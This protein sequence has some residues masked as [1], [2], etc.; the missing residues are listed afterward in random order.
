MGE[1]ALRFATIDDCRL[2]LAFIRELA[3]YE[4]APD[5]VLASEEDLRTHGFGPQ[6]HF[7][8]LI[9]TLDGEPAGFALFYPDFSTWRGR[10]GLFLEDL[11]VR[12]AA[13]GCGVGRR[14]LSRLAAI[15][16]ERGWPAIYFNVL[17]WNPAQGFYRRLGCVP[18]D[19]WQPYIVADA[20]LRHLARDD[21]D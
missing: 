17:H 15:T 21:R 8:A 7:E 11:F 5:A 6:P 4:R 16:V 1:I 12:E 20:A 2:L 19:E 3:A 9:A 13:R 18:R 14:L 10:P